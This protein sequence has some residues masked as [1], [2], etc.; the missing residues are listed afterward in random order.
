VAAVVLVAGQSSLA[1]GPLKF[2]NPIHRDVK[3]A[4]RKGETELPEKFYKKE[5]QQE[6][7]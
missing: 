5:S 3:P 1:F 7:L 6:I 2:A 4:I